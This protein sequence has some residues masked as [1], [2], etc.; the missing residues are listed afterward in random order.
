M[1]FHEWNILYF[2]FK[3][4]WS[5]FLRVQLTK[6]QH[7]F[8]KWLGAD[9]AT[10]HYLNQWWPTS[11]THI[12]GTRGRLVKWTTNSICHR[13]L[14]CTEAFSRISFNQGYNSN[15][16]NLLPME[17]GGAKSINKLLPQSRPG[18][19]FSWRP[20]TDLWAYFI[21]FLYAHVHCKICTMIKMHIT[22]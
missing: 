1:H 9:Q 13:S 22:F 14:Q 21:Y 6:S 16:P 15:F 4:R 7:W 18:T 12:C 20:L 3:F 10:S 5:W 2:F 11:L 8:R 17:L 19:M